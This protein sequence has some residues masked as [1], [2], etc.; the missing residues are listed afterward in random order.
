MGTTSLTKVAPE[1]SDGK[2]GFLLSWA[3]QGGPSGSETGEEIKE[4]W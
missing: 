4:R 2:V 1:V 3:V